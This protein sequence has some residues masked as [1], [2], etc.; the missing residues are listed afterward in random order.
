[1]AKPLNSWNEFRTFIREL[2]DEEVKQAFSTVVI[3]TA[4]IAY[5][6]CEKY[7]C[8]REST[9]KENYETISEIPYGRGYGLVKQEFDECIRKILQLNYGLVLISHAQD[10]TFTDENGKEYNKIIPTLDA[11]GRLICE[12]TCDI[13]GYSRAVETDEGLKTKLFMRGTPR[14]MAGSRFRFTPDVIDFTYDNL[15]NAI[16]DAVKKEEEVHGKTFV[17]DEKVNLHLQEKPVR[18]F[19][20]AMAEFKSQVEI[21]MSI[22]QTKAANI[23]QIVEKHL[24]KNKKVADCTENQLE[25][26]ELIIEDM[27]QLV[28]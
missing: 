19:N 9:L 24:G 26:L 7:I 10:K 14:F 28:Q 12:R 3:D 1:M 21:I 2:E 16:A 15:V 8:N 6:C 4:D 27:K 20:E 22:D 18:N 13:I 25:F 11:R 23:Q 5:A 17:T